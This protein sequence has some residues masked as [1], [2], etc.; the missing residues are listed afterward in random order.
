MIVCKFGGRAT[1]NKSTLQNI[2]KIANSNQNRKVFV[3]SAIGKFDKSDAKLTDLLFDLAKRI[4]NDSD[5]NGTLTQIIHKLEWLNQQ[6]KSG[7]KIKQYLSNCIELYKLTHDTN[8]LISRGE[9]IT[10][11]MMSKYLNIPFVPAKKIMFFKND[12]IDEEKTRSALK[13]YLRKYGKFAI[14][15]ALSG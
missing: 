13:H 12:Q 9:F 6:T 10:C 7:L 8:F 4:S 5:Y 2:K 11:Y 3:F 15:K 1:S 14:R